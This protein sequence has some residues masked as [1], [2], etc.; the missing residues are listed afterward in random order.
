MNNGGLNGACAESVGLD[1]VWGRKRRD[2]L[3]DLGADGVY[4]NLS[5]IV[6]IGNSLCAR[7]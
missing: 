6:M 7:A 5:C 3:I 1:L 4:R 2:G